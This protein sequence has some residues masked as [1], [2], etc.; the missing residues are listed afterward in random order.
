LE[1]LLFF[2]TKQSRVRE[3]IEDSLVHFGVPS[4]EEGPAGLSIRVGEHQSQVLFAFDTKRSHEKP[5]GVVVFIRTCTTDLVIMHIAVDPGYTLKS[6]PD[7]L[8]LGLA[9]VER[10]KE[11]GRSIAGVQRVVLFYRREIVI[12]VRTDG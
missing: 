6:E 5:V 9:L 11:I 4:L 8:G 2:N 7:R 10:V 3:G 12:P 1:Q